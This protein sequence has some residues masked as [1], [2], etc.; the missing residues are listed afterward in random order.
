MS[1]LKRIG[2]PKKALTKWIGTPKQALISFQDL[3]LQTHA[4]MLGNREAL[5]L[6]PALEAH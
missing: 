3:R 5:P 1:C 4:I 2:L 6:A